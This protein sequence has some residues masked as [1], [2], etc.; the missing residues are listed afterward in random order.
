MKNISTFIKA[1]NPDTSKYNIPK[2]I[3]QTYKNDYVH[4]RVYDNIINFL[5]LNPDHDY[6]LITDEIGIDLIKKNFDKEVFDAFDKLH[7]GAAK[8][9]FLR[10][11]AIYI[12][13]GIYADT[14]KG[15]EGDD[16]IE[17]GDGDDNIEGGEGDDTI[18]GGGGDDII[19][20]G[21]GFDNIYGGDGD[22]VLWENEGSG[23]GSAR[24]R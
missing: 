11:I 13:G 24:N 21:R 17:G 19:Y 4:E 12:Y 14:L 18:Y 22:D 20:G 3:I 23:G 2:I 15:L 7:I 5:N 10:L 16:Y 6:Y 1:K 8:G 9:D